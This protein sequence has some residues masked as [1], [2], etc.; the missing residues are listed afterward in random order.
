[1]KLQPRRVIYI[2]KNGGEV[3]V[4]NENVKSFNSVSTKLIFLHPTIPTNMTLPT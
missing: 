3:E 2:K 4:M 1:M